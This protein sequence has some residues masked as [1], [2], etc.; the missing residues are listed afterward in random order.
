MI[1]KHYD[2]ADFIKDHQSNTY[3]RYSE[4]IKNKHNFD[5][6]GLIFTAINEPYKTPPLKWKYINKISIDFKVKFNDDPVNPIAPDL[7]YGDD[8]KYDGKK[9]VFTKYDQNHHPILVK[10]D[11]TI[12]EII[13][14]GDIVEFEYHDPDEGISNN[15]NIP[16]NLRN[17][18]FI[19][20]KLRDDKKFPNGNTTVNTNLKSIEYPITWNH[21]MGHT[22]MNKEQF[23]NIVS[24]SDKGLV[25]SLANYHNQI[26]RCL[27]IKAITLLNSPSKGQRMINNIKMIDF[28]MGQG[29][30]ISKWGEDKNIKRV[31]G[32]DISKDDLKTAYDRYNGIKKKKGRLP[33]N[34]NDIMFM[35]GNIGLDMNLNTQPE[36]VRKLD[37]FTDSQNGYFDIANCQFVLSHLFGSND[38]LNTFI[39]NVYNNLK[40]GGIFI[41]T[42]LNGEKVKELLND[43]TDYSAKKDNKILWAFNYTD[44]TTNKIKSMIITI[45]NK[46]M[47]EYLTDI[48]KFIELCSHKFEVLHNKSFNDIEYLTKHSSNFQ[49]YKDASTYL[50]KLN[51]DYYENTNNNNNIENYNAIYSN[52]HN[53]IIL[54][55]K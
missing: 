51:K 47:S 29:G 11:N 54:K 55:R 49:F 27:L 43:E 35:H 41:I 26:K 39:E 37:K 42:T 36:L 32:I 4:Y 18:T 23:Y 2:I 1:K 22:Q 14:N 34:D 19:P 16:L 28:G 44:K 15:K 53:Y 10:H 40:A 52:L 46:F 20:I 30:D 6:D 9:I 33:R 21:L 48:D 45:G 17:D 31:F 13:M 8:R 7:F 50:T 38:T 25:Q 3:Q 5:I 24:K 12:D